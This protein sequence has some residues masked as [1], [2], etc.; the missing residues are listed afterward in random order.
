MKRKTILSRC[1]KEGR[2]DGLNMIVNLQK[3][4]ETVHVAAMP[5]VSRNWPRLV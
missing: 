1:G 2:Q 5:N 4:S 3:G